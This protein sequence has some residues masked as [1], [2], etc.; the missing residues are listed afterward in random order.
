VTWSIKKGIIALGGFRNAN[1]HACIG[2][3]RKADDEA[4]LSAGAHIVVGTP[5]RVFELIN[6]QILRTDAI[7]MFVVDEL[8]EIISVCR[9]KRLL[10]AGY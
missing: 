1:I 9:P 6:R 4:A 3:T 7:K 2:G 5:S 10:Y 8:D